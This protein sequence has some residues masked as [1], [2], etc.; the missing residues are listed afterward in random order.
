MFFASDNW[1]GAAPRVSQGLAKHADGFEG[2]YGAGDLDRTVEQMFADVFETQCAVF[3]VGT[4]TAANSLAAAVVGCPGG[5]VFSQADGHVIVSEGGAPEAFTS[6]GRLIPVPGDDG[7]IDPEALR[8]TIGHYPPTFNHLGRGTMVTLSQTTEA[9]TVYSLEQIDKIVSV[10]KQAG[11]AV[12][13]D[14][15]RFANAL[16]A[17]GCS[18]AEMTWKRGVDMVSFGATKNG[19]WCA[20]ALLVF[21]P[22]RFGGV[23]NIMFQRKRMGHLFSKT[24]FVSA[25]FEAYFEDDLWLQLAGHS[26]AMGKRLAGAVEQSG[27]ARLAW[28]VH[29]NQVFMITEKSHGDSM[30]DQGAQFYPFPTTADLQD[31]IKTG[32][33]LYRMVTSF[34]TIEAEIDQFAELLAR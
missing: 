12:H 20:D 34:A 31:K 18:P 26:N 29:S 21:N 22:E 6:G 4:G 33:Q 8:E 5:V 32:E 2:A 7:Y 13:M 17:L 28:P 14:G 30:L 10:A 23:D 16:V 11:L 27:R 9:G 3:V 15:A 25:Q 24:R 19:C 1:A